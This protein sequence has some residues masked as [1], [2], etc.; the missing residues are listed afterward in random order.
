M[1]SHS[2]LP[3]TATALLLSLCAAARLMGAQPGSVDLTFISE[4]TF[5][6]SDLQSATV[7][8]AALQPDGKFL[9]GVDSASSSV[10][11]QPN[12]K[13]DLALNASNRYC[14]AIQADGKFLV[15]V[16]NGDAYY[17]D[18]YLNRLN[19]DGSP[20]LTFI[21]T[22]TSGATNPSIRCI[23]ILNDGQILIGGGF[24]AL[25]KTVRNRLARL[26]PNGALDPVF[27]PN[28]NGLVRSMAVQPD[29]R[30]V[31]AGEFTTVGA[32]TRNRIARLNPDG[33]LDATFDPNASGPVYAVALQANG[34]IVIGGSFGTVG[35]IARS[36]LA[37]LKFDGT[38]DSGFYAAAVSLC[39]SFAVQTDGRILA[40]GTGGA[41]NLFNASGSGGGIAFANGDCQS[42]CV[43]AD[44]KILTGGKF[45]YF[46]VTARERIARLENDYA[47]QSLTVPDAG[48][49]RW[50]RGG[51]SPEATAVNFDLSTDGGGTWVPLGFASRIAGGWQLTGLSLPSAG[52]IR[53]R[54]RTATGYCNG[55][56][57]LLET[58]RPFTL[59]IA[60]TVPALAPSVK[61]LSASSLQFTVKMNPNGNPG[62]LHFEY[63]TDPL[64][65]GAII[66]S[67]Q[68]FGAGNTDLSFSQTINGLPPATP[69]YCTAVVTNANGTTRGDV[70]AF[71]TNGN[72][73]DLW[74][75]QHFGNAWASTYFLSDPDG[76]G[77]TTLAEYAFGG[78]PLAPDSAAILPEVDAAG[79]HLR[80][81]FTR[82]PAH[83]DATLIVQA[84]NDLRTWSNL[85]Q[86]RLG[87]ATALISSVSGVTVSESTQ[88]ALKMVQVTDSVALGA[89]PVR[90]LRVKVSR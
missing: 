76:D 6:S 49:V 68:A 67:E 48:Q 8:G 21:S 7:Y 73:G 63:G 62:T 56:S 12:G 43:Q 39:W 33:S 22:L 87:S 16:A 82:D 10:R 71:T 65:A 24:T 29:G 47:T 74:S 36:A 55:S 41:I 15:T 31:I 25:N 89:V 72:A 40:T 27:N 44:G 70:V 84:S 28:V 75:F 79:G 54:A 83:N 19:P 80:I 57:S 32:I 23:A 77:A 58:V 3:K 1:K 51:T 38:P 13:L 60:Q 18:T 9:V 20:D 52:T 90:A 85:A 5:G 26:Q 45:T 88:G 2:F 46:G 66:T 50:L 81:T 53:A 78:D 34:Q 35:G 11:F 69:Y 86:S 14:T 4:L 42:L 64:L 37:R 17:G 59:P 30:I 61:Y